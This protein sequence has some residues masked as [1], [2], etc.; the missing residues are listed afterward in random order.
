MAVRTQD[1]HKITVIPLHL[2]V[3]YRRSIGMPFES[4]RQQDSRLAVGL[5]KFLAWLQVCSSDPAEGRHPKRM[6]VGGLQFLNPNIGFGPDAQNAQ[7]IALPP[8]SPENLF[9]RHLASN[10]I[11]G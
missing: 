3:E 8:E 1:S 6:F 7:V 9:G 2:D 11:P 5:V 4:S 10:L